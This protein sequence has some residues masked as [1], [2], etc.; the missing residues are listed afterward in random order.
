MASLEQDIIIFK[1]RYHVLQFTV[2]G[3]EDLIG[4]EAHWAMSENPGD[5]P[6]ITK[7]T[8]GGSPKIS[9]EGVK[10]LVIIDEGD[11]SGDPAGDYYHELVLIDDDGKIRQGA[12]GEVDLRETTWSST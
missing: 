5:S 10:V 4:F 3:V 1:D 7:S 12:V 11:F 2:D 6:T 8:E 9:I